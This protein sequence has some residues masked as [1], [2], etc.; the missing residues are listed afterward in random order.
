MVRLVCELNADAN[1]PGDKE[2]E[3]IRLAWPVETK[4]RLWEALSPSAGLRAGFWILFLASLAGPL[5]AQTSS[6]KG[7][8]IESWQSE[9][10]LP[11]NTVTG[12]AQTRDRYLWISTLDGLARFDGIRFR[13]YKGGNTPELGSGRIRFLFPGRQGELWLA[14]QEGGLVRFKDGK[15][16]SLDLPEVPGGRPA[17]IQVAEDDLG[18]LWLST[19][20]GKVARLAEGGYSMVSTNWDPTGK[21]AFQ[22][23]ADAQ[24]QLMAVSDTGL[25]R[26]TGTGLVPALQGKRGEYMV[27]CPG[28]NGGWWVGA[29]GQVRLW[30][31]GQWIETIPG[32]NLPSSVT[33]GGWED[34]DGLWL[35]TWGNG[36]FRCSTNGT[37]LQFTKQDGLGSDFV[38]VVCEDNEGNLWV[39]MEGGGLARLRR[40]L[41]TVYGLAPGLSWEWITTVSEGPDGEVWVG[42]DGYGLNRLGEDMIRPAGDE[43]VVTPLHVMTALA[44]RQGQVWLGTRQGGL[45]RWKG[46][47]ATRFA[48]FPTNSSFVRSLFQDSRQAL[49]V[50]RRN[51][52]RLVRIQNGNVSDLELPRSAG[53]VD[54]RVMAED[55]GGALWFGTDGSGLFRWQDGQFTRFSRENGLGSDLIWA[56]QPESTGA[57]WIG[58]YGGG[59]TRLKD[60]KAV[61]CTTRQ[62]L[63]DDVIC[64]IADDGRGQYWLSSHQ[65]VFRVNKN[66]LNQFA[67]GTVR[68][69]H[70]VSYGKQDGL[71]TLECRGGYQ[72][73][74]CRGGD[75]RLWFPTVGGVVV[76]DPSDARSTHSVAPPVYLEEVFVDGQLFESGSWRKAAPTRPDS[77][78]TRAFPA[79][80][81]RPQPSVAFPAGSRRF[82]F[83]YAGVSLSAPE[84]LR[85][86]HKLEGVD[87]EWVETGSRRDASYTRLAHGNYT[88]RV[89]TCNREGIWGQPGESVTFRVLPFFWQ[90]WWFLGLFL[91]TFGGAVAWAVGLALRRR[92][93]RHLALVHRLHAAERER[94]RIARDIHD[95]LGSSLTEIGLLGALAVRESTPPAEA[96]EQVAR[97]M[98]RAEE[99]A[100]KL[101]ETVWA[102][103][104]KNDSLRHL[105]TYLCNF[106][107]EFLEPTPIRCRLDVAP[108]LPGIALTAE[109]RHNVFLVAKEALNNAI[110]HSGAK[111]IGLRLAVSDGV[112]T[113]EVADNGRGFDPEANRETG[114]GLRNM[115]ER[116]QEV[117]GQIEVTS[118]AAQGTTVA[119]RLPIRADKA[120]AS[121]R[122]PR[123]T[124]LG[125]APG[126][127]QT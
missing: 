45:F 78:E 29:G 19:E 58:T 106:A 85:F 44:D 87:A 126:D 9:R 73:A 8:L 127:P 116:M 33:R 17:V 50:G 14:T 51:T 109:V 23:L 18:G 21:T 47:V 20:D 105:A 121:D 119:L 86:R 36:L 27:H 61:T 97:M 91:L 52:D 75:G 49:W 13:I 5:Q 69:V 88:F 124:R 22:V 59:L 28:R 64:Y 39:G 2:K 3:A 77:P 99:L 34:H 48:G 93:Q 83:H 95:D 42:T 74:G 103:N 66:E 117:G 112:F 82:E 1:G 54:V 30:R 84:G 56:L 68:T 100:R 40:P 67:D 110:R 35:R 72:P 15:F 38:R 37:V 96:R 114:D 10:G 101:D 102:V 46:G 32:L 115:A 31:D 11:Q 65:G 108:D 4:V 107:K 25:Y 125:D 92:H 24:G 60:G 81:R 90:T 63:V 70:C 71:P 118:A 122:P 12:I 57:L 16:T 113:L 7:Y 94:T 111:E 104:P 62:G 43:P 41:F 76:V 26:V 80:P 6:L 89:Q 120:G 53:P 123:V 55:A 79:Q 98:G